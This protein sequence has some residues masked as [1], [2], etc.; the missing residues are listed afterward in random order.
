MA[1]LHFHE[2]FC[3]VWNSRLHPGW[4]L[5]SP[6]LYF[7]LLLFSLLRSSSSLHAA[8]TLLLAFGFV[9]FSQ[10]TCVC[11]CVIIGPASVLSCFGGRGSAAERIVF[12]LTPH[13]HTHPQAFTCS[14]FLLWGHTWTCLFCVEEL[15]FLFREAAFLPQ[16]WWPVCADG[17][18]LAAHS[19]FLLILT[20]INRILHWPRYALFSNYTELFF[21]TLF[22]PL[23]V[24][25]LQFCMIC[26][27]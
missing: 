5:A 10:S 6:N 16:I 11:V 27:P 20:L 1:H 26:F 21:L 9:W 8:F 12:A 25:L 2:C 13:S 24:C 17:F 22:L 14:L 23:F 15:R 19:P 3:S 7:Y 4:C 18:W